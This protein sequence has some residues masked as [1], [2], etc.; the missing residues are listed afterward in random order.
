MIHT[1]NL[2]DI[3]E[4]VVEGEIIQWLKNVGDAV[5]QDEPVVVV[6]TDKATVELPAPYPG[7]L[8]KQ[9]LKPGEIAHKDHPVYDLEVTKTLATPST[10]YLA[11]TLGVDLAQ[12]K[13][14][15]QEGRITDEDV[16]RVHEQPLVGMRK[17]IAEKT[18][19]SKQIIPHFSFF[20]TLDAEELVRVHAEMKKQHPQLSYMPFFIKALSKALLQFPFVN[21][22]LDM[23]TQKLVIHNQH[24]IGIATKTPLGLAVFVLRDVQEMSFDQLI[25]VYSEMKERALQNKLK[26][27]EM[28]DSTITISNF[29]TLGGVWATPIINYPE[30]AILGIA[31]IRKTAVVVGDQ[32]VPRETLNLSWSFDHRIIDGDSAAAFSNAYKGFLEKPEGLL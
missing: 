2:P 14:S 26:R 12:V 27:E 30:L 5:I 9:Y 29:G 4:G 11:Q 10:R 21:G 28:Q 13:G 8:V 18:T 22:S 25:Q 17:R 23:S 20:D 1:V 3:G 24:H 31:K 19:E 16:K 7:K 6:M 32:V 15:G